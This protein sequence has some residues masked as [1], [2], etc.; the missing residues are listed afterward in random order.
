MDIFLSWLL[1]TMLP[2][3][4][5]CKHL[6]EILISIIL[7]KHPDVW[8]LDPMVALFL[9]FL[10]TSIFV[11]TIVATPVYIFTNSVQQLLC[12]NLSKPVTT[13]L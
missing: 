7:D 3:M 10:G 12:F 11:F 8:M 1:W 5:E 9:V 6:F 4:W 2:W 13:M